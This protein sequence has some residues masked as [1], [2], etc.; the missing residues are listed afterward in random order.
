M[1]SEPADRGKP[2][3]ATTDSTRSVL[4]EVARLAFPMVL[5]SASA[6]LMHFV[7]VLLVSK[8]GTTDLAAVM[9]AGILVFCFIAL[10]SGA[11]S[12]VNTFVSQSFGK[13]DFRACSA[14]AWQ[15][16]FVAL[17]LGAGVLP[18]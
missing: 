11:S 13:E 1:G 15:N 4:A 6:T 18:L 17:I 9:P 3:D 16:T 2:V 7:D 10:A 12:C 5:A 14:Y 8:L